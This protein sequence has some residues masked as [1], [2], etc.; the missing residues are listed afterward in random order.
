[1]KEL[2]LKKRDIHRITNLGIYA[3][4]II[5]ENGGE[6]FRVEDTITRICTSYDLKNTQSFVT[7]TV[8]MLSVQDE[9]GESYSQLRRIHSRVINLEKVEKV[10]AISRMLSTDP[11]P[12]SELDQ[13]LKG[14]DQIKPLNIWL[15]SFFSAMAASAFTLIFEGSLI[16][17]FCAFIVG[18]IIRTAC[19]FLTKSHI[20]SFIVNIIGG[21]LTS[22]ITHVFVLVGIP[23]KLDIVII[24]TLMLLVPG[25]LLTN[26]VRDVAAGD[27]ISGISR[28]VEALFIAIALAVGSAFVSRLFL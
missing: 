6:I 19:T 23:A 7:P 1:M 5:L 4:E 11:L 21:G 27:L 9:S 12:L 28:A 14:I 16:D 8:V 18:F 24:S 20:N 2:N 3:G 15:L 26:A 13:R 17:F 10:N 25:M 22:L